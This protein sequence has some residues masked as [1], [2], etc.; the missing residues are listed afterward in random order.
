MLKNNA[1]EKKCDKMI[2]FDESCPMPRKD[3]QKISY[4]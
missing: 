3:E 2:G 1:P 4:F